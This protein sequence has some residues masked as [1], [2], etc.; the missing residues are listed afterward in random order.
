MGGPEIVQAEIFA[1]TQLLLV[2]G[3]ALLFFGGKKLPEI[4]SGL[5]KAMREFQRAASQPEA[6]DRPATPLPDPSGADASRQA[7]T[8]TSGGVIDRAHREA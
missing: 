6:S 3:L 2:L 7:G 8:P 1:P 5:G 4:A